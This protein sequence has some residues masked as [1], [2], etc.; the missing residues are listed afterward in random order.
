MLNYFKEKK[1]NLFWPY[2][3]EFFKLLKN[4]LFHFWP[5]NAIFFLYIDLIKIRL[6]IIL[7]DFAEKKENF[8]GL[9]KQNF[10]KSKKS[11]FFKGLTHAFNQ[12]MPIFFLYLQ[13]IK[14]R[15]EIMLSDFTEK[16][17]AFFTLKTEF[18]S[19]SKNSYFSKGVNLC[20]WAKNANFS[21]I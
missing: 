14:I 6:E 20:F 16:K 5:K 3:N 13:L 7:S 21:Y 11:H 2:K 4:A 10:W 15:L 12:K 8:F 1:R 17:K 19:K 9:K 18:F